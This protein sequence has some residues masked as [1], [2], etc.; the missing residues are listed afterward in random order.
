MTYQTSGASETILVNFLSRSSLATGPNTRVPTGSPVSF[1]STAALSSKRMY[2]PSLRRCSLRI[3]TITHFT[4]LAS[5]TDA[6][7]MSPSPAFNPASPPRGRMHISFRAPELSATV[8][9]VRIIIMVALPV[10]LLRRRLVRQHFLQTPALEAR[11]RPGG[12]DADSV[13]LLRFALFIVRVELFRNAHH[14]AVLGVLHQP[15]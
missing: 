5:F 9:Q 10:L 4:T 1:M 7:T 15:L 12:H 3:R 6:V 8:S 13:S 14:A 2:V 11:K